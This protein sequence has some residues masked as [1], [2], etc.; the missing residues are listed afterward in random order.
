MLLTITTDRE[1]AT[2]LGF[3]LHKHPDRVQTFGVSAGQAQVFY[4]EAAERR[5]TV[6]LLLEVDPVELVRGRG[7]RD[8]GFTLGQYVNDRPYAASSLLAVA[9]NQVFRTAM[10]GRCDKKPELP[11]SALPLTI[12][13]P[14]LPCLGG[15]AMAARLFEP[16]GW[17]VDAAEIPLDETFPEWGPSRY[18]DLTLTGTMRLAEA[19]NHLYVMMPVLDD[20]KHYWVS[21]DEVDKLIRAGAGWLATHPDKALISRRYLNHRGRLFRSAMSR[22]AEI[23]DTEP[24]ELDNAVEE[25]EEKPVPLVR[26]RHGAVLAALRASGAS[27]VADLGCGEGALVAELLADPSFGEVL[28]TDVSVRALEIAARRLRLDTMPE[29]KKQRLKLFQSS[30]SY[31]DERLSEVDAAVLMEVI[32]HVDPP[33]LSALER[34]VFAE[35]KPKTVIVTT[36]NGEYNVRWESLPAGQFR[37]RD[38]RFEWSREE[39]RAWSAKT[40][41]TWGYR[42]R[43]LPVGP[44]DPEVGSPTQMAVFSREEVTG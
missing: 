39:F 2:D 21:P 38:H 28:A 34:A 26:Q 33:R 1:P 25:S 16:L 44:D 4:P 7:R 17:R 29:R 20:A 3:L 37:H 6:A 5:C 30:L 11:N 18:V 36:P 22:L 14:V 42:F 24:E 8:D 43:L 40:A 12:H 27:R 23:D 41:E 9:M 10:A 32:E 35:A 15:A 31:R 13:V 19:L